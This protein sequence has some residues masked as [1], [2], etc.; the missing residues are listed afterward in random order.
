MLAGLLAHP[1]GE[2]LVVIRDGLAR[3]A[4]LRPHE[5]DGQD[6]TCSPDA[7]YLVTGGMGALG[8]RVAGWLADRGARRLVLLGRTALPAVPEELAARGSASR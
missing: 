7:A 4:R 1:P 5:P 8:L 6:L 2:D 3:V